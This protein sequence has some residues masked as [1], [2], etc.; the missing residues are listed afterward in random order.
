MLGLGLVLGLTVFSCAKKQKVQQ[1]LGEA[2]FTE[3][4]QMSKE[5]YLHFADSKIFNDYLHHFNKKN[6]PKSGIFLPYAQK[7]AA[8][9]TVD[10]GVLAQLFNE[11][12]LLAVGEE[13][14]KLED[15]RLYKKS[16]FATDE[17]Y[18]LLRENIN[19]LELNA[20]YG[21]PICGAGIGVQKNITTP[22][23]MQTL[24]V[25]QLLH[26]FRQ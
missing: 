9:Q 3:D 8:K 17:T 4:Y 13:L 2:R 7:N 25:Q 22:K 12:G 15:L 5:G 11:K 16:L 26:H 1:G 20:A 21:L 10:L 19:I 23:S 6:L 18:V 14:F 24:M